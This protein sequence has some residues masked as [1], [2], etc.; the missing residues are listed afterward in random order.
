M[1]AENE[2]G[3]IA[4]NAT[5]VDVVRV[6]T[7]F[8]IARD[9]AQDALFAA[10]HEVEKRFLPKILG[11]WG[12]K[13]FD[14]FVQSH[15]FVRTD[16]Y[17]SHYESVKLVIDDL[18]IEVYDEIGAAAASYY[19]RIPEENR[20]RFVDDVRAWSDKHG[21]KKMSRGT[22][23]TAAKH[24]GANIESRSSTYA[25]EIERLRAENADLK[26]QVKKLTRERDKLA[27]KL[28]QQDGVAASL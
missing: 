28:S 15:G 8:R 7:K 23:S 16:T 27:R 12:Y 18:G 14:A 9:E 11:P 4:D 10:L 21:G 25:S 19:N 5:E 3:A 1:N 13:S 17:R 20:D 6:L 24:N 26:L 2:I 22:A